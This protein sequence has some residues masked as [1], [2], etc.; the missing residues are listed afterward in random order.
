MGKNKRGPKKNTGTASQA[1]TS[2]GTS[3]S[4]AD[5]NQPVNSQFSNATNSQP[6]S[7]SNANS[8][9]PTIEVANK[10][11][12]T[13]GKLSTRSQVEA[14]ITPFLE[15]LD[16]N[17]KLYPEYTTL[18]GV[19]LDRCMGGNINLRSPVPIVG[20]MAA[21]EMVAKMEKLKPPPANPQ[22]QQPSKKKEKVMMNSDEL[23][24]DNLGPDSTK[25]QKLSMLIQS[26]NL[27]L[28]KAKDLK[29][30]DPA[31]TSDPTYESKKKLKTLSKFES[32]SACSKQATKAVTHCEGGH[33]IVC[34]QCTE[35]QPPELASL[36]KYNS[37]SFDMFKLVANNLTF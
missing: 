16:H 6:C 31:K 18:S 14:K 13:S 35:I 29:S 2:T 3:T 32:S 4:K 25:E 17:S 37:S 10:K 23:L 9:I 26:A 15:S 33:E 7:S 11:S 22:Q 19:V 8:A 36:I 5:S 34:R 30:Y 24:L 27:S 28:N 12:Q 20:R 21:A 1:G